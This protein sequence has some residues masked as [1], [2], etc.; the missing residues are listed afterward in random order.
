MNTEYA[1]LLY[2]DSSSGMYY[3]MPPIPTGAEGNPSIH[4]KMVP[5][6]GFVPVGDYHTHGNYCTATHTPTNKAS[7][8]FHSDQF[9]ELA[10]HLETPG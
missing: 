3:A 1:G 6:Q 5:N 2:Q 9:S 4:E 8:V 10:P 7:D